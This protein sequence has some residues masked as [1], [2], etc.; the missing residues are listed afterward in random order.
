MQPRAGWRA[1]R[2]TSFRFGKTSPCRCWL[3][4]SL[5]QQKDKRVESTI[6]GTHAEKKKNNQCH[7]LPQNNAYS[8]CF[9]ARR[10]T[11]SATPAVA[12]NRECTNPRHQIAW[13]TI[14]C[15]AVPEICMNWLHTS[16]L[17][18]RIWRW[19]LHLWIICALLLQTILKSSMT[20]WC[21][22]LMDKFI[23]NIL[24]P[25]IPH[26]ITTWIYSCGTFVCISAPNCRSY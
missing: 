17:A 24:R 2:G 11:D 12:T 19:L 21:H 10:C 6:I 25:L 14:F 7:A 13:P 3:C 23:Y 5:L 1:D 4:T 22:N 18:P 15:I 9:L 8:T 26:T 20:S 16:L